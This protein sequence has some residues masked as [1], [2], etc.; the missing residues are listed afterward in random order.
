MAKNKTTAAGTGD[1]NTDA[2]RDDDAAQAAASQA[3]ADNNGDGDAHAKKVAVSVKK[4][5]TVR[6]V[7]GVVRVKDLPELTIA[8]AYKKDDGTDGLRS[9]PNPANIEKVLCR[10]AGVATS[11]RSGDSSYGPWSALVGQFGAQNMVTGELISGE[12]CII[13]GAF[14]SMLVRQLKESLTLDAGSSVSFAVEIFAKRSP[15]NSDEKYEYIV[16]PQVAPEVKNPAMS[17][18]LGMN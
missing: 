9:V 6:D 7:F 11:L 18:L 12:E 4:K 16:R 10:I 17:L 3:H 15:K 13:P 8:E 2:A 1:A 14:G 5:L